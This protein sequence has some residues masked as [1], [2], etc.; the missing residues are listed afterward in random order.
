LA[1][2]VRRAEKLARHHLVQHALDLTATDA[3]ATLLLCISAA[4]LAQLKN[5]LALE[6]A[7]R[8]P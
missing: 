8:R 3:A 6:A 5:E 2:L 7:A 1:E 4:Q